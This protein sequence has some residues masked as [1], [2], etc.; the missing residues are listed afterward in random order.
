[1]PFRLYAECDSEGCG[2]VREIPVPDGGAPSS[3]ERPVID[4]QAEIKTEGWTVDV[5]EEDPEVEIWTCPG[6]NNPPEEG[7]D[8]EGDPVDEGPDEETEGGDSEEDEEE[9]ID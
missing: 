8:E 9:E 7:P 1:M 6:C 5:S 2:T 3:L 4:M